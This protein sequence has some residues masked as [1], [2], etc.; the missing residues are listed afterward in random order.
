MKIPKPFSPRD[1][2]QPAVQKSK[3]LKGEQDDKTKTTLVVFFF[4]VNG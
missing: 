2:S 3:G 4:C 1:L